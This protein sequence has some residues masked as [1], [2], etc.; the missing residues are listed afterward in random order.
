MR[1]SKHGSLFIFFAVSWPVETHTRQ[2]SKAY[3]VAGIQHNRLDAGQIAFTRRAQSIS[4]HR[5]I[6]K[7]NA[8]DTNHRIF[9]RSRQHEN[10]AVLNGSG[11]P[12]DTIG[13]FVYFYLSNCIS[14]WKQ[15]PTSTDNDHK[16]LELDEWIVTAATTISTTVS[17]IIAATNINDTT[18]SSS[19]NNTVYMHSVYDFQINM[20][21]RYESILVWF[22]FGVLYVLTNSQLVV[23][24]TFRTTSLNETGTTQLWECKCIEVWLINW[25]VIID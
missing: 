6:A 1:A 7:T 21:I 5:N 19:S 8:S 15:S 17:V 12:T 23:R 20:K 11:E 14:T 9:Q 3:F 25:S 18:S 4:C 13:Q 22:L 10:V 2:Q 16:Q 24:I